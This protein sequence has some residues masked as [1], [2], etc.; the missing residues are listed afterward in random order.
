MN[1]E[2]VDIQPRKKADPA[3]ADFW[4]TLRHTNYNSVKHA[5]I[6]WEVPLTTSELESIKE[7]LPKNIKSQLAQQK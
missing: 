4:L 3:D 6:C 2:V 1:L 7:K 5:Y